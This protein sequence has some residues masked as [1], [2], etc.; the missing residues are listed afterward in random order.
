MRSNSAQRRMHSPELKLRVIEQCRQ[1]GVSIASVALAHGL[2]ANLVRQWLSG[3]GLKRAAQGAPVDGAEPASVLPIG[4]SG[5][6]KAAAACSLQFVPLRLAAESAS[7][8]ATSEQPHVESEPVADRDESISIELRRDA[9][10]LSV[11]WPASQAQHCAAWMR[12]LAP[13]L[14]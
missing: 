9:T 7:E 5:R 14:K 8:G 10:V 6:L 1:P 4:S 13:V 11:R 2:N 12:E 3:R